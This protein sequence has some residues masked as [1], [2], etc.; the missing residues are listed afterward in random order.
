MENRKGLGFYHKILKTKGG[1][2]MTMFDTFFHFC[3]INIPLP[4]AVANLLVELCRKHQRAWSYAASVG[5]LLVPILWLILY[6]VISLVLEDQIL[7]NVLYLAD[8]NL[9]MSLIFLIMKKKDSELA[10]WR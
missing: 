1:D 4:F 2:S 5:L 7:R 3:L 9:I 10:K 6:G 8:T